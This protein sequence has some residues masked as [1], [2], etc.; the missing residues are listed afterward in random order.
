MG[1]QDRRGLLESSLVLNY[2]NVELIAF[3][4]NG[5][6]TLVFSRPTLLLIFLSYNGA[7][8]PELEPPVWNDIHWFEFPLRDQTQVLDCL[9]P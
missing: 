2:Q 6:G 4:R 8:L 3:T 1:L 7:F 9:F 5:G